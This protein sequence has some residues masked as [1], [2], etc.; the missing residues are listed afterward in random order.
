M[1][2]M[3]VFPSEA[4]VEE[5]CERVRDH[6][7][8]AATAEALD[9]V[10]RLVVEPAG[11]LEDRHVY[12]VAIHPD[13]DAGMSATRAAER[14]DKPRLELRATYL[15]WRRLISG[16]QD[17]GMAVMLRRL[18]V[19]GDLSTVKRQ[20]SSARPLTDALGAVDTQWLDE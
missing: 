18:R 4:W 2:R 19:S 17:V 11:P 14:V 5:F 6:P 3:P 20:M 10:Y 15:N 9:G 12:D 7:D 16:Q 8:A 1:R 13:G